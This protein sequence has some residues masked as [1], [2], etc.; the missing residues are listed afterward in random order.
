MRVVALSRWNNYY[1]EGVQQMMRDFQV[2][3]LYLD[4]IAYDRVTMMRALKLLDQRAGV[5]DHHSDS[6]AFCVSPAMIYNEHYPFID[7]LCAYSSPA[8]EPF[9][10][11][12]SA[13]L[14]P[15]NRVRRRLSSNT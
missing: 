1:V 4:E 7:K 9:V 8:Y 15:L 3:G 2:D 10:R 6:G 12:E 13:P 14:T 11:A 5:I